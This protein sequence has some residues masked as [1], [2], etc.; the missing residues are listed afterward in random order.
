MLPPVILGSRTYLGPA[1]DLALLK[2]DQVYPRVTVNQI[3]LTGK[4]YRDC[5]DL[6]ADSVDWSAAVLK[7]LSLDSSSR[8]CRATVFVLPGCMEMW[9]IYPLATQL[10]LLIISSVAGHTPVIGKKAPTWISTSCNSL[11]AYSHLYIRLTE[12]F[13]W[14]TLVIITDLGANIF[15]SEFSRTLY[16]DFIRRNSGYQIYQENFNTRT[17]APDYAQILNR[18]NALSRVY[19]YFG[20]PVEFRRMLVKAWELDMVKGEHVYVVMTPF[21]F[22]NRPGAGYLTWENRDKDDNM[23]RAAY[24]SVLIIEPDN[25]VYGSTT[26]DVQEKY[27]ADVLNRSQVDYNYTYK[28]FEPVTPH[29][30]GTYNSLTILA[31]VMEDLRISDKEEVWQSGKELARQFMNRSFLTDLGE[32]YID[33]SGQRDPTINVNHL[34][35]NSSAIRTLFVQR[36]GSMTLDVVAEP[37]WPSR[38]PPPDVPGCGFRGCLPQGRLATINGS[39]LMSL[40]VVITVTTIYLRRARLRDLMNAFSWEIPDD[41]L[42]QPEIK[43]QHE[44]VLLYIAEHRLV[45]LSA[46]GAM[47]LISDNRGH[48]T[49]TRLVLNR[50]MFR[51]LKNV[52]AIHYPNINRLIGV[53]ATPTF[54]YLVSEY[55]TRGSL[56]ELLSRMTLDVDFQASLILDALKGLQAVHRSAL[57]CH[58]HLSARCCLIDSHFT[59]KLGAVGFHQ[60]RYSYSRDMLKNGTLIQGKKDKPTA[61]AKNDVT[62]IARIALEIIFQDE[63]FETITNLVSVEKSLTQ[64]KSFPIGRLAALLPIF[65][66][67]WSDDPTRRP[68]IHRLVNRVTTVL[69]SYAKGS[70]L[71]QRIIRRLEAYTDELDHQVAMRTHDL[72]EERKRCDYLLWAMLPSEVVDELRKGNTPEAA[73]YTSTT[74]M[75]VE[76]A[77]FG[78]LLYQTEPEEAMVFLNEVFMKFDELLDQYDVYKVETIKESY[79]VSSGVPRRNEERHANEI[80]CLVVSMMAAYSTMFALCFNATTTL[81]AGIHS[82][83]V[84]AGVVGRK[85]P[86]YCLFGDTIN[87]ASRMMSS[88]EDGRVHISKSCADLLRKYSRLHTEERGTIHVKGKGMLQTY[89]LRTTANAK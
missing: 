31:Q 44:E 29:V 73:Y 63:S 8:R 48:Q 80:C 58:G 76:I 83:A 21:R 47:P 77:G 72:L 86:R 41:H 51:L 71:T 37:Q 28:P 67:C 42:Q 46:L 1:Y 66:S 3:F 36:A 22:T 5:M 2:I 6:A 40:L 55:C 17:G 23:A 57:Q 56:P 20:D 62:V 32:T 54:C 88:G 81:R 69:R 84:A 38:W 61:Q 7:N 49:S 59:L 65:S 24:R 52:M 34:D 53:T 13:L 39:V 87:T 82:G 16:G 75:F 45:Y 43:N 33:P 4:K 78:T 85:A 9:E 60:L 27:Y 89:W 30:A 64:R 68:D 79:L 11:T 25:S 74:I 50:S 70:S 15:F 18:I 12:K 19:L 14:Q 26:S 35:W 10:D